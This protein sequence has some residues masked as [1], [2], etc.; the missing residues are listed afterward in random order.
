MVEI[1]SSLP[2]LFCNSIIRFMYVFSTSDDITTYA[3]AFG[4]R[5]APLLP[6]QAQQRAEL[7]P[8]KR[9][10]HGGVAYFCACLGNF[11]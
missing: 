10:S 4:S 7:A 5:R 8:G 2:G 9:G 3:G 11:T 6:A 1:L